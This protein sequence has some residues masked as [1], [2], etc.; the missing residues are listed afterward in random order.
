MSLY[1]DIHSFG[2]LILFGF[3]AP[4]RGNLAP[5]HATLNQV[6]T[7]QARA[8]DAV[9]WRQHRNYRVGNIAAILGVAS[10]GGT[11]WAQALLRNRLSYAYELPAYR[12]REGT[13]N[14]FLVE[15]DFIRQ[16]GFETW[17]GIKV[18]ARFVVRNRG[19]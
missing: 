5:N 4:N 9:K 6:G 15:P 14:G 12:G 1:L 3:A 18:A 16:A 10:G 11:D 17:E 2:S 8:I 13:L 7:Q 19:W